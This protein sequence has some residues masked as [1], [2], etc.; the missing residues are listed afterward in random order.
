MAFWDASALVPLCAH[1]RESAFVRQL[2]GRDR[3][4]TVWWGTSVELFSALARLLREG[5]LTGETHP[6][7]VRRLE[8]LRTMWYEILPTEEVRRLAESMPE[9][10][11]LRALDAFQLA[12]ALVWCS[13]RPRRRQFVCLDHRLGEAASR[14]GFTAIGARP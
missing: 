13:E 9:H 6:S 7:A 3:W 5:M 8:R 4:L 2:A 10:Y 11:G 1:R 14:M 12:A